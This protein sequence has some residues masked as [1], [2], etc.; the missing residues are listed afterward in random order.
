MNLP[1]G[2]HPSRDSFPAQLR[3]VPVARALHR[4]CFADNGTQVKASI[5]A[6]TNGSTWT[7]QKDAAPAGTELYGVSCPSAT[8][9]T[10]V[11]ANAANAAFFNTGVAEH[12]NGTNWTLQATPVPQTNTH[13]AELSGISSR[14]PWPA[15]QSEST[16]TPATAP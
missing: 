16:A 15:P 8:T 12:W 13:G 2:A 9:C 10:A 3:V 7:L 6:R 5:V 1:D 14:R 11:G 4:R